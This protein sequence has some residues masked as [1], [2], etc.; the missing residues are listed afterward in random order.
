[1]KKIIIL[2]ILLIIPISSIATPNPIINQYNLLPN[3]I[4]QWKIIDIFTLKKQN[5]ENQYPS[6]IKIY[7]LE[8]RLIMNRFCNSILNMSYNRYNDLIQKKI[9]QGDARMPTTLKNS[10]RVLY[11]VGK[12]TNAI[13]IINEGIVISYGDN[14]KILNIKY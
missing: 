8:N 14:V 13:G 5:W 2:L 1:M 6:S 10:D 11:R 9:Y 4:E 3:E 7:L 12:E